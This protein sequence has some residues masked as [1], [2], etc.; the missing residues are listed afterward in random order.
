MQRTQL[1]GIEYLLWF[2]FNARD[3][4]WYLDITDANEVQLAMGIKIVSNIVFMRR[5]ISTLKPQGIMACIDPG[6]SNTDPQL[7]QDPG[8]NTLGSRQILIY[9]DA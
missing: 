7:M 4:R 9:V 8:L 3:G 2:R 1:D 5:L 6:A